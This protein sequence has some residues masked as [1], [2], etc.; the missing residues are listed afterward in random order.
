[1]FLELRTCAGK[2]RAGL[3]LGAGTGAGEAPKVVL[4]HCS[5]TSYSRRLYKGIFFFFF[6]FRS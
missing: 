6:R 5:H 3:R 4:A 1:M 2:S